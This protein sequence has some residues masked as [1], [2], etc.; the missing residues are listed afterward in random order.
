MPYMLVPMH[1]LLL[2]SPYMLLL[3]RFL[4]GQKCVLC[5]HEA[6][7]EVLA[8]YVFLAQDQ[9]HFAPYN[10]HMIHEHNV[11][12]LSYRW[13]AI[14]TTITK[15]CDTCFSVGGKM[16]IARG[17]GG[18]RKFCFFLLNLSIESFIYSMLLHTLC[19]PYVLP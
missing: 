9:K 14:Q 15:F 10:L 2:A 13:Y 5:R 6:R 17:S 12:S 8:I 11:K 3:V 4:V 19:S 16:A 1:R 18:D 7:H